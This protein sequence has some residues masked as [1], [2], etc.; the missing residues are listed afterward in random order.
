MSVYTSAPLRGSEADAGKKFCAEAREAA[1]QAGNPGGFALRVVCLDASG[2]GGRWTLAQVGAN[3]RQATEDSATVAY[4]GEPEQAARRQS[5]PIIEAAAIAA[6]GG[7]SGRAAIKEVARAIE[8]G[9][10]SDPRRAVFDAVE[11]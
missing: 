9:D 4:L 3:A 5:Q 6:L 10:S 1:K 11:G 7:L 2:P 8:E